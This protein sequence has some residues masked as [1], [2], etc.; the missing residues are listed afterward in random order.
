[1]S[2]SK[3]I[4][5]ITK[6]NLDEKKE[7]KKE[8][9]LDDTIREFEVITKNIFNGERDVQLDRQVEDE[10]ESI[11]QSE[12]LVELLYLSLLFEIQE[13][14]SL[15]KQVRN[16]MKMRTD[17]LNSWTVQFK[18]NERIRMLVSNPELRRNNLHE[19]TR[20]ANE[21]SQPKE[22]HSHKHSM[23]V[24]KTNAKNYLST[25]SSSRGKKKIIY[26]HIRL[27]I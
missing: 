11:C 13:D 18:Q 24:C 9:L 15:E 8:K 5:K 1:M 7:T 12:K 25:S 23:E 14:K 2:L 21:I 20:L 4:K 3:F 6:E 27:L 10:R 26:I 17:A 22:G 19:M 16:R